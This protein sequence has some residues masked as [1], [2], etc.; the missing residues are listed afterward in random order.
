[1]SNKENSAD[2]EL[3]GSS[4]IDVSSEHLKIIEKYFHE[5]ILERNKPNTEFINNKNK[6]L[7]L[8]TVE[9]MDKDLWYG[10][11]GM[12]GGFRYMLNER[13]GK[14]VLVVESWIR[15]VAGS[16]RKHEINV[17]GCFLVEEE[18]NYIRFYNKG[19]IIDIQ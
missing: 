12:Y 2:V 10:V 11:P 18:K 3:L 14:P 7:P 16:W 15:I 8:I 13:D 5:F 17:E 4:D 19:N 9:I 6:V 1:M